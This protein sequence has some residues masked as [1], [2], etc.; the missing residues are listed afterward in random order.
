MD[1][2]TLRKEEASEVL[3]RRAKETFAEIGE[4]LRDGVEKLKA[5]TDPEVR[6]YSNT[7]QLFWKSILTVEERENELESFRREREGIAHGYALDL[8]AARREVGRRLA[9]LATQGED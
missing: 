2:K 1:T 5:S 3:L 8:N 6:A 9:C 4:T 7:L